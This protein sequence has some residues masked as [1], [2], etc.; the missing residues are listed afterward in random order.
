MFIVHHKNCFETELLDLNTIELCI[1]CVLYL[2]VK[3]TISDQ[4]KNYQTVW[5]LC[6]I[7]KFPPV[8]TIIPISAVQVSDDIIHG[9]PVSPVSAS[10]AHQ[11]IPPLPASFSIQVIHHSFESKTTLSLESIS[12]ANRISVWWR[13]THSLPLWIYLTKDF[14][15]SMLGFSKKFPVKICPSIWLIRAP[16]RSL[17]VTMTMQMTQFMICFATF[18]S[19]E[20]FSLGWFQLCFRGITIWLQFIVLNMQESWFSL[21]SV[22]MS[23]SCGILLTSN[24]KIVHYDMFWCGD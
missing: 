9:N 3:W 2:E 15:E 4:M 1:W 6:R 16:R 14:Y 13:C 24:W 18:S 17:S 8:H 5:V 19:V 23:R 10:L 20:W 22:R 12:R 7:S 21:V 11:L